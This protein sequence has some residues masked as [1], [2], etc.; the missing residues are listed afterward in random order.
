MK[1]VKPNLFIPGAGKS[2]TSSLHEYLNLHT[3]IFM[4]KK[5]EPHFFSHDERYF[6]KNELEKYYKLFDEGK[7]AKY[8]GESSTGYMVFPNTIDRIKKNIENPKFIFVLRNPIDR[9][10]SHYNWVDS[11][12]GENLSL[13]KAIKKDFNKEPQSNINFEF[14]YRN[15]FQFGLYG[16]WLE[17]YYKNFDKKDILIILTE[18]LKK[19]PLQTINKCCDFL[20]I[21]KFEEIPKIS[22]NKTIYYKNASFYHNLIHLFNVPK[23]YN[24]IERYLPSFLFRIFKDAKHKT[25]LF[26]KRRQTINKPEKLTKYQKSWLKQLYSNDIKKLRELTKM[27]YSEWKDFENL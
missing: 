17:Q 26:I 27:N 24:L 5:K 19:N 8:R 3:D 9:I 23:F 6:N 1:I 10:F 2:G 13:E 22:L 12:V 15:Y 16:K 21:S 18:D 14:G 4:S 20:D 25:Y 11:L 7:N